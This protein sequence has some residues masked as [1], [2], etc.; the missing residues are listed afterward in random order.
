M[1]E[2]ERVREREI[3]RES[4]CVC[5]KGKGG[6]FLFPGKLGMCLRKK[7]L[8][9]SAPFFSLNHLTKK[10]KKKNKK[11]TPLFHDERAKHFSLLSQ[12]TFII[13]FQ[14]TTISL[15]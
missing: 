15:N 13:M 8:F 7:E 10:K 9:V 3:E 2:R 5:D 6:F 12:T 4:V 1:T 14:L 11:K